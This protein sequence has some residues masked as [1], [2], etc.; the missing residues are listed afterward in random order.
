MWILTSLLLASAV[1]PLEQNVVECDACRLV[2]EGLKLYAMQARHWVKPTELAIQ[3]CLLMGTYTLDV[4]QGGVNENAEIAIDSVLNRIL[5]PEYLCKE[6][7]YCS[8]PEYRKENFTDWVSNIMKGKPAGPRPVPT[9]K[10]SYKFAHMSDIHIDM[11]YK[12]GTQSDCDY[13]VCCRNGTGTAGRWGDYNC[14]LPIP[15]FEAALQQLQELQPDFVIITGDMP[16][17]DIWEQTDVYN[18]KYQSIAGGLVQKYF[19]HTQVYAQ[20]G[21]HACFPVNQYDFTPGNEEW[22][23]NGFADDW[24][25]WLTADAKQ[26]LRTTGVYSMLHPGSNLRIIALNTQA[27]NDQNF[28]L[29]VNSTDP[30]GQVVWLYET[31]LKA[32]QNGELVYMFGHYY[33]AD[34]GC[35]KY[36]SYHINALIDR[37][38][39][40]IAGMF[41]GHSHSD[42]FHVNRAVDSNLPTGIQFVGPSVTT[43]TDKNP[44]FRV[45]SADFDTKQVTNIW[46]YRLN[47]PAANANPDASPVFSLA[48]DFKDIYGVPDMNLQTLYSLGLNIGHNETLALIYLNNHET[49]HNPPTSCDANC[50]HGLMCDITYGVGDQVDNCSGYVPTKQDELNDWLFPAWVYKVGK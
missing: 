15:T 48:Y 16:P 46:Q 6:L 8:E 23:N 39:N 1:Q 12:E 21:N 19:P 49:G 10:S 11:F 42:S 17:H 47:L 33:L 13:P 22:L 26:Q 4:C 36:W 5:D 9:G 41:F 14:D 43:Y 3:I 50:Q 31:L 29:W 27:C 28:F 32:E 7:K 38:E 45:Y 44:S 25:L 20:F 24:G 34:D 2:M 18:M 30:G 40:T 37:F 35:L